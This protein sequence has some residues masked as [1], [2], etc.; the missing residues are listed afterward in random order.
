MEST[1]ITDSVH[2]GYLAKVRLP[3]LPH[4]ELTVFPFLCSF[5]WDWVTKSSP[6]W[7]RRGDDK[8]H[9]QEGCTIYIYYLKFSLKG[10]LGFFL[11]FI[12][13]VIFIW[14]THVILFHT[15]GYKPTLC[16]FFICILIFIAVLFLIAP[17][18]E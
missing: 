5:L 7:K 6:H 1:G 11:L 13:S 12:Y 2:L 9:P 14:W 15:L 16:C 10:D 18:W 3:S 8:L 17:N 4:C